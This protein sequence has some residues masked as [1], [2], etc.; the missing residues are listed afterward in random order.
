MKRSKIF[1]TSDSIDYILIVIYFVETVSVHVV[2]LVKGKLLC[3][4]EG[5]ILDHTGK[6]VRMEER[7]EIKESEL[8]KQMCK[9]EYEEKLKQRWKRVR[10]GGKSGLGLVRQFWRLER[11]CAGQG[12]YG[13]NEKKSE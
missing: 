8:S 12:E 11:N 10:G 6:V 13:R 1:V 7:Y 3:K 5:G 2:V 4:E 9:T